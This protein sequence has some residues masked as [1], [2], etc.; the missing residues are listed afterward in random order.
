MGN[1]P[2][3]ARRRPGRPR[4]VPVEV[5]EQM[6]LDAAVV[7]FGE[8]GSGGGSIDAIAERAGVNKALVYEHV[9]SKDALFT[10]AV[11]RERDRLVDYLA[12]SYG[13]T[14]DLPLRERVRGRFHAFVDFAGEHPDSLRLLAL[15][16]TATT[17]AAAGRGTATADL[18]GYLRQELERAGLPARELPAVLAAMLVGASG[19]V[20]RLAGPSG[21]DAEAVVDLLTDFTIAGLAGVDRGLLERVDVPRPDA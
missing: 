1:E 11:V 13:R 14:A 2:G 8:R 3:E 17:L 12:A 16:E 21:W 18:T 7:V 15:P 10:A 4:K 6:I 20:I 5:R 9:T 19:E